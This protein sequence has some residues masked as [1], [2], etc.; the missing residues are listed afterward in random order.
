MHAQLHLRADPE[1]C[2]ANMNWYKERTGTSGSLRPSPHP[3][4]PKDWVTL[5]THVQAQWQVNPNIWK[6]LTVLLILSTINGV[7]PSPKKSA[8][9]RKEISFCVSPPWG[10]SLGASDFRGLSLGPSS[11][12]SLGTEY[13]LLCSCFLL[14]LNCCMWGSFL[15]TGASVRS[16]NCTGCL[17][18]LVH[19]WRMPGTADT[20]KEKMYSRTW[21][22]PSAGFTSDFDNSVRD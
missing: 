17:F 1:R 8:L 7:S 14:L 11:Y 3:Q 19:S 21:R 15:L 10:L 2:R 5:S 4:D 12:S 20:G 18:S 16:G 9:K 6:A 13:L 22:T